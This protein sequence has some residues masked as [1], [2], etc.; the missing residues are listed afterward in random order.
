MKS[1]E[2]ALDFYRHAFGAGVLTC[3]RDTEGRITHAEIHIADRTQSS[4]SVPHARILNHRQPPGI[5]NFYPA[6]GGG[7]L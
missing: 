3:S 4:S 2:A 7:C 6:T 5:A 1:A